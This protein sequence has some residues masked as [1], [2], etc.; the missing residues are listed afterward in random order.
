MTRTEAN[1]PGILDGVLSKMNMGVVVLDEAFRVVLWNSWMARHSG[2]DTAAVVG[3]DFFAVFPD[4][5]GKRMDSAIRHALHD[6]FPSVLS[7]TLHKAPLALFASAA[8]REKGERLQQTV[9]VTP[10]AVAEFGR[11]CLIQITDVTAAVKRE[12][13]LREQALELRS[14][15]YSDGLT[16]IANRRHFDVAMDKET[17]RAKRSGSGLSLI[18][19]D[20]DCFK[21]Y[22]DH[23]GHQQGDDTLIKVA[24]ALAK[25]LQRPADLI[26]RYGGEEFAVILPETDAAQSLRLA[27]AMRETVVA[28]QIAHAKAAY[29]PHVTISI[30]VATHEA[31]DTGDIVKLLGSADRALY[32]AKHAGRNRVVMNGAAEDEAAS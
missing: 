12:R 28:L 20:I 7:Q 32:M 9:A 8:A 11:L 25:M 19:I 2:H 3:Q 31:N 13:L 24:G 5:Q 26:A 17:R 29:A 4:L 30:G 18:M 23:Y 14:Q 16:G 15:S 22:N 10:L 27:E 1:R 6:N 21:A